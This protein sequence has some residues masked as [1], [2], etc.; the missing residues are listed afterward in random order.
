MYEERDF[1]SSLPL[2]RDS[3]AG[4]SFSLGGV[5]VAQVSS[6]LVRFRDR[7]EPVMQQE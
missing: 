4:Q 7:C 6:L 5:A 3:T 1:V 2:G